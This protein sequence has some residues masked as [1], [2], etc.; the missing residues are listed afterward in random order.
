M[1]VTTNNHWREFACRFDV[2]E[3][4]LKEQFDYLDETESSGFFNYKGTW[5][6]TSELMPCSLEKWDDCLGYGWSCG[7]VIKYSNDG[8]YKIGFY[9]S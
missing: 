3:K 7:V 4:V 9:T 8:R 5:H 6:H 2:P 1:K